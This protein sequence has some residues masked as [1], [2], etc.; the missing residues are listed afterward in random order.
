[1][2]PSPSRKSLTAIVKQT[3][4]MN[5]K[6][7]VKYFYEQVFSNN[8]MNEVK[9]YVDS[10]CN[11]RIGKEVIAIGLEGMKKHISDVRNTYPDFKIQVINQFLDNEYVISEIIAEGTHIGEFLGIKPT[12][13]KLTFTGVDI[14][15]VKN[16]KIVEHSGAIN[17]F[18]TFVNEKIIQL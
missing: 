7:I 9:D 8:L 10:K 18:E 13:K 14:D 17:T 12:G 3:K 4:V 16:G 2:Q 5:P 6:E 11:L 1:M 15:R